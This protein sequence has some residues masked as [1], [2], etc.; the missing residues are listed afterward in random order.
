MDGFDFVYRVQVRFRDLDALGHLNNAVFSTYLEQARIAFL[1]RLNLLT[2]P[3]YRSMILA[4]LEIDFRA[5]GT[6]E[7]VDI[8]VRASRF[9]TKSFDL[10]YEV[11]QGERVVAEATS[12][13]VAFDYERNK[14]I[15][16]PDEWRE[17]LAA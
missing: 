4:R 10:D 1:T 9:G 2:G 7:D 16:L 17:R 5:Q 3:S 11:R 6:E 15:A 8:G 12:V 14:A 13:L